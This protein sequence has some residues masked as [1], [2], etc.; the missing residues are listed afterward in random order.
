MIYAPGGIYEFDAD[1]PNEGDGTGA[2]HFAKA[3]LD[4]RFGDLDFGKAIAAARSGQPIFKPGVLEKLKPE[5]RY[6]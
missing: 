3:A 2:A 1:I 4:P 5:R 6:T